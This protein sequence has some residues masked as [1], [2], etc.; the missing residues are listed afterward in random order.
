MGP[1]SG[2]FLGKAFD[3][4]KG[5]LVAVFDLL[6]TFAVAFLDLVNAALQL[7]LDV[8][9]LDA[10]LDVGLGLLQI[11]LNLLATL[12]QLIPLLGSLL[13]A[14][15]D[16]AGNLVVELAVHTQL[17]VGNTFHKVG[18]LVG[19]LLQLLAGLLQGG[20]GE[21]AI[22]RLLRFLL[23]GGGFLGNDLFRG[24]LASSGLFGGGLGGSR[25]YFLGY[26]FDGVGSRCFIDHGKFLKYRGGWS[27][28]RIAHVSLIL[29]LQPTIKKH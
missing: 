6:K 23:G 21:V 11:L 22:K 19:G 25:L 12:D 4:L 26:G 3:F 10:L 18:D 9:A 24:W 13:A 15:F 29:R 5:F 14:G 2:S 27:T 28:R 17:G 7:G 16:T 1:G 20:G 8:D